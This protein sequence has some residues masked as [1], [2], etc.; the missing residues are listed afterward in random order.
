M[1]KNKKKNRQT[2]KICV[3]NSTSFSCLLVSNTLKIGG[4]KGNTLENVILIMIQGHWNLELS[5]PDSAVAA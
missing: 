1:Y 5:T 4:E 2:T 3:V